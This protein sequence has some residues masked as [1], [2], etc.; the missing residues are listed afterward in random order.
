MRFNADAAFTDSW[1]RDKDYKS[2]DF[3]ARVDFKDSD[4]LLVILAF[5]Y[6]FCCKGPLWGAEIV[7]VF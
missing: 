5:L 6:S 3:V 4:Y 1:V 2:N 7:T